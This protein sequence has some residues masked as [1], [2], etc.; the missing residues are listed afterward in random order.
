VLSIGS[1]VKRARREHFRRMVEDHG[2]RDVALSLLR[3]R[4]YR[5]AKSGTGITPWLGASGDADSEVLRD[6]P[7]LRSR[8]REVNRDDPIGSG[9]IGSFVTNVIGTGMRPQARTAD[10]EL[11]T[12][13]EALWR[14][15][16]DSLFRA[17]NLTHA[18]GQ[19]LLLGKLLEDGEFFVKQVKRKPEESLWFEIVEA[20]RVG[21]PLGQKPADA[22][23]EIRDGIEK[24]ADGV[25]VA[26]W[27]CKRHP[28]DS[29]NIT[30]KTQGEFKRV[31]AA[32]VQHARLVSRP[33]QTRG[34]PMFHAV[35]QDLRDLDLLLLASLKRV[36]I[37]ACL[38]VFIKSDADTDAVIEATAEKYGYKLDQA[39]E[40]GM[41]FRLWPNE[42]IST[43]LPNF[44]TPE[45]SPF[46][47]MLARRIGT[48]VGVSWQI[49]LKDFSESTYSSART[50]LLESR[51]VFTVLQSLVSQ[52]EF[53][54][55]WRAVMEDAW[56][57]GDP[58][59]AG[60]TPDDLQKVNWIGN[61]W[62]W[63]DPLNQAKAVAL[64]LKLGITCEQDECAK[65][66]LDYEEITEKRKEAKAIRKAAGLDEPESV[67]VAKQDTTDEEDDDEK[68]QPRRLRR[69]NGRLISLT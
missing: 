26:Y 13:L 18:E 58:R 52:R 20:D 9:L 44:P 28:G 56:L 50:D 69:G 46:I 39:L 68:E 34:V 21:A 37:A 23:G 63:V 32:V 59:L 40:P 67:S 29:L 17:E 24:D 41:M 65:L 47:I 14:E 33:G 7:T 1:P 60:V 15:R 49:V 48:A 45:L 53:T 31:E 30:A 6:L 57:R 55:E 4:G 62:V 12:A 43:I 35:L 16:A 36:Q 19:R 5:A 51:Q 38:A 22:N 25:P 10:R 64:A 11:N 3:A 2:Y 61:G 8:A 27:I 42:D 66:G 54:W